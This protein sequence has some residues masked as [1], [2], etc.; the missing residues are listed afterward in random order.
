VSLFISSATGA[1]ILGCDFCRRTYEYQRELHADDTAPIEWVTLIE[2]GRA[3][4]L[5][6]IKCAAHLRVNIW[7]SFYR[8]R[9]FAATFPK[10][11]PCGDLL[12]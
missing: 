3:V 2:N 1:L 12:Q 9:Y 5:C 8:G 10:R 4:T 6:S 11:F 7:R